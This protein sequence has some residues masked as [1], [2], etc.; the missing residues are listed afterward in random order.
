MVKQA[1]C[2]P[3]YLWLVAYLWLVR[4]SMAVLA[5]AVT[6]ILLTLPV[7]AD[8]LRQAAEPI[9]LPDGFFYE[10]VATDLFFPVDMAFLPSGDLLIV[11][12]GV[13][14][15]ESTSA[16]L[17]LLRD[18][19]GDGQIY[20]L[21]EIE[22]NGNGD[23]GLLSVLVDPNFEENQAFYLWYSTPGTAEEFGRGGTAKYRLSRFVLDLAVPLVVRASEV[24]ILDGVPRSY[25]HGGGGLAMN[26]Q[27]QLFLAIGDA[28]DS[29]VANHVSQNPTT[30]LG[31]ILR[32][33]PTD[34]GYIVPPD[35]PFVAVSDARPEIFAF[36]LRNP[37]RMVHRPSDDALFVGDVGLDVWEE[38]NR[39]TAGANYGWPHREGPCPLGVRLPCES[40]TTYVEPTFYYAHPE[41]VFCCEGGSITGMAF[42]DGI[43]FPERYHNKLF[44]A[45]YNLQF[46]AAVDPDAVDPDAVV[47]ENA[48]LYDAAQHQFAQ[49]AGSLT[50][51]E[52]FDQRLYLLDINL[53]QISRISY[54]GAENPPIANLT[55]ATRVGRP[56]LLVALDASASTSPQGLP[57]TYEWHLGEGTV[58]TT[59]EP[60]LTHAY[61]VDGDYKIGLVAVDSVMRRSV[62]ATLTLHVYSG[63]LPVIQVSPTHGLTRTTFYGGDE[64]VFH[65]I[66]QAGTDDLEP[67]RSFTWDMSLHHNQ[68]TH[69]IIA[70][71]D[72]PTVT[73]QIPTEN[74]GGINIW[75]EVG[76]TM[77]TLTGQSIRVTHE[78]YPERISVPIQTEPVFSGTVSIDGNVYDFPGDVDMIPNVEYGV[79]M[80][81]KVIDG[82]MV[83]QFAKWVD[84]SAP[85]GSAA[86]SPI[87]T[88]EAYSKDSRLLA[89]YTEVLLDRQIYVPFYGN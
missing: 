36:G 61:T 43:D 25:Y 33:E 39:V 69:P 5:A 79:T 59:T 72:R 40:D 8:A 20:H 44:V 21:M 10:P 60:S 85:T 4:L 54:Y 62:T 86:G 66:R 38:L 34:T 9:I 52:Y 14:V 77:H 15:E 6:S 23:S 48:G 26:N 19:G 76:L 74:H 2:C 12:K 29:K 65:P 75:Y 46:I 71:S 63:E 31:K 3:G 58:L 56:P 89:R 7:Q 17:H 16:N 73:L 49:N 47:P 70:D 45:D 87:R 81:I 24:V 82:R 27:G 41:G 84:I 53:G 1:G 88:I 80:P 18:P 64:F 50:D 57:L 32:V 78:I 30:L 22:V 35:N 28:W 37:F 67:E 55:T 11:E 13:G 42:Y 83:Y 51:I 68:H